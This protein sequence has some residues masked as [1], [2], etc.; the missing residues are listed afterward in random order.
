ML[1]RRWSSLL[2]LTALALSSCR[3]EDRTPGGSRPED[4]ALRTLVA[5]F[6]QTVGHR[7]RPGLGRVVFPAATVLLAGA[8]GATLVPVGILIDVPER[9]NDGGGVRISRL[10]LRPDGLVA[11]ARVVVVAVN[12]IDGREFEATDFLTIAFRE[13]AWRIAQIACGPWR[14]RSAP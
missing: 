14:V 9:R 7:D 6:Y 13:G 12:A 1:A 8:D 11:T 3:F 2:L 4:T 5:D 10:D